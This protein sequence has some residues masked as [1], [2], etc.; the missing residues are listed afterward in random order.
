MDSDHKNISIKRANIGII[1]ATYS[2]LGDIAILKGTLNVFEKL[3]I[4]PKFIF[5]PEPFFPENYFENMGIT[6]VHTFPSKVEYKI[7]QNG[8][9]NKITNYLIPLSGF[10][11][12][13]FFRKKNEINYLYCIGGSRFGIEQG[14]YVVAEILNVLYKKKL[15][16]SELIIGGASISKH[17]TG[18]WFN[19]LY[20]IFANNVNY[21]FV[22]DNISYSNLTE[23][24]PKNKCSIIC[25]FAYWI[26]PSVT[27]NTLNVSK[28]IADHSKG[29]K[30]IAIFP[31]LNLKSKDEY[32]SHLCKL[33]NE[34][35]D[36]NY[37]I[38]LIPTFNHPYLKDD[39]DVC[40]NINSILKFKTN[41]I[42][43]K[44]LQPEEL[45][46]IISEFDG[47]I[48]SRLHG[49][50]FA[51]L[52]NVPTV[53]IYSEHKGKG[54]FSTY[55]KNNVCL[56]SIDDIL[57]SNMTKKILQFLNQSNVSE[58]Y[59]KIIAEFKE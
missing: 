12:E 33:I 45:I 24:L 39:N 26:H 18:K 9:S 30:A 40:L 22:R 14:K 54:F 16:G 17:N 59:S 20:G 3:G 27:K 7:L 36:E 31:G 25:D 4:H 58:E 47:V 2:N 1:R 6:A 41:I 38:F 35:N 23:Y 55:F 8:G 13:L 11:K 29:K 48:S 49:A 21:A 19:K 50:I 51:T 34:L 15:L 32:I 28:F 37:S 57:K 52:A 42:E 46:Q 44:N 56:I 10:T 43:T 5:D 53:H